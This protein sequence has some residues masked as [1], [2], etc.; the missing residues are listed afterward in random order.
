[1][2][3]RKGGGLPT[4]GGM[5]YKTDWPIQKLATKLRGHNKEMFKEE[6][7]PFIDYLSNHHP[8]MKVE[9]RI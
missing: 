2:H 8:Y 5:A 9:G 6:W 7:R 3:T 1:M 4:Q